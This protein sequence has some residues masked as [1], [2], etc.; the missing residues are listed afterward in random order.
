MNVVCLIS[1]LFTASKDKSL[2]AVDMNTGGVAHS[3]KKAHKYVSIQVHTCMTTC[4]F[5][6]LYKQ[7]S[8]K[9][10][11]LGI[12]QVATLVILKTCCFVFL[13]N[14]EEDILIG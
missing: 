6:S 3:I 4:H 13:M 10:P 9:K 8:I 5:P 1:D 11:P 2:Q 14:K 7:I 12:C